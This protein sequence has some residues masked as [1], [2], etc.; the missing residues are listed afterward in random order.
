MIHI[1]LVYSFAQQYD[2]PLFKHAPFF[3]V[4]GLSLSLTWFL[5]LVSMEP[6]S[7]ADSCEA[8]WGIFLGDKKVRR[9]GLG[10]GRSTEIRLQHHGPRWRPGGQAFASPD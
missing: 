2:S 8:H 3:L 7:D 5:R 1:G 10:R 9:E 6:V 4:L